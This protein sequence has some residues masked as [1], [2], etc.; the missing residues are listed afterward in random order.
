MLRG[1]PELVGAAESRLLVVSCPGCRGGPGR[2]RLRGHGAAPHGPEGDERGGEVKADVIFSDQ[3]VDLRSLT[4]WLDQY[5]YPRR[6]E[7]IRRGKRTTARAHRVVFGRMLGRAPLRSD[8][9]DH[10]NGNLLD[11]RRENLRA[12][13]PAGNSQNRHCVRSASGFR[14]VAFDKRSSKWQASVRHMGIT[15]YCGVFTDVQEA[16]KASAAKR[17]ELGFLTDEDVP[18]GAQRIAAERMRQ[19][20][21]EGWTT[22]HDDE[23]GRGQLAQA[24]AC[25]AVATVPHYAGHYPVQ[26]PWSPR[27]DKR[28]GPSSDVD[29]RVRALVKAGALCAAEIDRLLRAEGSVTT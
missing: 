7:T 17:R 24:A 1:A 9:C 22:E 28:P 16:A 10:V 19:V 21:S 15:Y 12:V 29:A 18:S 27:W 20:E 25:Y 11:C 14:G 2:A 6:C 3:D 4:W 23:Q 13:S 5:G 26:W 8:I